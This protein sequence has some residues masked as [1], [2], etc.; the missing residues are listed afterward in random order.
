MPSDNEKV[1]VDDIKIVS[2]SDEDSEPQPVKKK[3]T[4]NGGN[5]KKKKAKDTIPKEKK[6]AV[7]TT[8]K[9]EMDPNNWL[10]INLTEEEA[11]AEF[12]SRGTHKRYL[13]AQ[14]KCTDC[15]KGF[16]KEDML[17]RHEK[18]RHSEVRVIITFMG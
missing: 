4:R 10:K 5:S 15:L 11:E 12:K 2:E 3:R 14:Y 13:N 17:K 9:A 8:K 16:S 6:F 18:L 7:K 1:F